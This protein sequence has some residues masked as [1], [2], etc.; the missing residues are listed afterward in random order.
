[1]GDS[2]KKGKLLTSLARAAIAKQL[3][4]VVDVPDS[5][6]VGWLQ[7]AGASF[8][9]LNNLN[10]SLRGCVGSLEAYRPLI[11]DVSANAVAA[12][13]HDHRF[14][15]LTAE[16]FP[17]VKIEVSVLTSLEA[18]HARNENIAL[19][20]LRPGIDGVVFKFGMYKSTFLPQVWSQLAD[21]KEFMGQLKVKAGLSADFWHPE[22]LLYKYQVNKY[23]EQEHAKE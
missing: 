23:R 4:I 17:S 8:V 22:V 7:D 15:P 19:S 1:M 6:G 11:E 21:P 18:M 16:E 13:F 2:V 12:A 9:T 5:D 3:E 20:R 10:G 14:A